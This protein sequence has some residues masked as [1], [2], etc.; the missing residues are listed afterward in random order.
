MDNLFTASNSNLFII[1]FILIGTATLSAS[2]I[3][4]HKKNKIS[5]I[6][7]RSLIIFL[8]AYLPLLDYWSFWKVSW[9]W[10]SGFFHASGN[11]LGNEFGYYPKTLIVFE[12]LTIST[13]FLFLFS[14]I[15]FIRQIN[16]K[17]KNIYR[18]L[19]WIPLINSFSIGY[20]IK[21]LINSKWQNILLVKLW[22]VFSFLFIYYRLFAGGLYLQG[23]DSITFIYD[24]IFTNA[25]DTPDQ[26]QQ[27]DI[28]Y[29]FITD[30]LNIITPPLF[31]V[32]G[33]LT[34]LIIKYIKSQH[35]EKLDLEIAEIGN[36]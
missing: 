2:Y 15:L 1:P 27:Y 5:K 26:V 31:F 29:T 22:I 14:T 36:S 16:L 30:L 7:I 24:L 13:N 10:P 8:I 23:F 33:I 34:L 12:I 25:S 19:N 6:L 32:S 21:N 9:F 3:I 28:G 20:Q 11:I 18:F 17:L 35:D 4:W